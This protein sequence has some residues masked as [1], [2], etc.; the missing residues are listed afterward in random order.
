MQ[1]W[2]LSRSFP[3]RRVTRM[4]KIGQRPSFFEI[5]AGIRSS[6]EIAWLSRLLP[7]RAVSV[8]QPH[9]HPRNFGMHK[10][11]R[12][13]IGVTAKQ[14]HSTQPR[15][16]CSSPSL[17]PSNA[18]AAIPRSATR[19]IQHATIVRS[20]SAT[21]SATILSSRG[22][23]ATASRRLDRC[24]LLKLG[25][26]TF[27]HRRFRLP[28]TRAKRQSCQARIHPHRRFR[29]VRSQSCHQQTPLHRSR[30]KATNTLHH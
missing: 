17:I 19:H 6:L 21:A 20:R 30:L 25:P 28:V 9:A 4:K 8:G 12:R 15:C 22:Q 14:Q 11:S 18:N 27:Q 3:Q 13:A 1:L 26:L 23:A 29:R 16:Y 2:G 5:L 10:K 24:R 7:K